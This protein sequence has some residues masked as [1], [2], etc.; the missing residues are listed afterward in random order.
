[1]SVEFILLLTFMNVGNDFKRLR[2]LLL[3]TISIERLRMVQIFSSL[4]WL[5]A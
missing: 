2:M 1:M 4:Y 5:W 3:V